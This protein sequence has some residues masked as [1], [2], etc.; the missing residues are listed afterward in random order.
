MEDVIDDLADV[1]GLDRVRLDHAAGTAVEGRRHAS[2]SCCPG[3]THK[4]HPHTAYS[5]GI[6]RS[7]KRERYVKKREKTELVKGGRFGRGRGGGQCQRRGAVWDLK[8]NEERFPQYRAANHISKAGLLTTAISFQ[9][10]YFSQY[11]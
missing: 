10:T 3:D 4:K 11:F 5:P 9:H 8:G 6:E 1:A 2:L 7:P